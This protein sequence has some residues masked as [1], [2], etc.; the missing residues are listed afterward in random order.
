M[1]LGSIHLMENFQIPAMP[2]ISPEEQEKMDEFFDTMRV[3]IAHAGYQHIFEKFHMMLRDT[4]CA[5]KMLKRIYDSQMNA[6][7][8]LFTEDDTFDED[9]SVLISYEAKGK[10]FSAKCV[11]THDSNFFIM[12]FSTIAPYVSIESLDE[13]SRKSIEVSTRS[14]PNGLLTDSLSS[15]AMII[16]GRND[17][18]VWTMTRTII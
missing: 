13:T 15:A 7:R 11:P 9:E 14:L 17:A 12:P 10:G 16:T 4:S 5:S 18:S 6:E 1:E 8:P 2:D 3:V